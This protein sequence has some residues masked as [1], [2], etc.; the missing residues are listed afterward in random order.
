MPR[1]T[2][3]QWP[4]T[5]E[6]MRQANE[7]VL[8]T[9]V[10]TRIPASLSTKSHFVYIYERRQTCMS[11]FACFWTM[12]VK[13]VRNETCARRRARF[14]HTPTTSPRVVAGAKSPVRAV[15]SRPGAGGALP[16]RAAGS[17]GAAHQALQ[18]RGR[19]FSRCSYRQHSRSSGRNRSRIRV[20]SGRGGG[21]RGYA[22][23][24]AATTIVTGR[25][26]LWNVHHNNHCYCCYRYC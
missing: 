18:A 8:G 4:R 1:G 20:R 2:R 23:A 16:R 12:V 26:R 15:Q 5:L 22:Q 19:V 17:S 13:N 6:G 21:G 25:R 3:G 9:P 11:V 7:P 14:T 24:L 10:R